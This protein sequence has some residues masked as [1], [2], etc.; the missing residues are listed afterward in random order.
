[1][2]ILINL[3]SRSRD[4]CDQFTPLDH[5]HRVTKFISSRNCQFIWFD[6]L[7][8][9]K[10][11]GPFIYS[12]TT[13][14]IKWN[15]RQLS[16]SSPSLSP[17]H[18]STWYSDINDYMI[19]G[20]ALHVNW[21]LM[22]YLQQPHPWPSQV[23]S[24][25]LETV[26]SCLQW[27]I[28]AKLRRLQY[29]EYLVVLRMIRSHHLMTNF[30]TPRRDRRLG[31]CCCWPIVAIYRSIDLLRWVWRCMSCRVAARFSI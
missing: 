5:H 1:M 9:F 19:P 17:S 26:K 20:P 2:H 3:T 27:P 22:E 28:D 10:G 13:T 25:D 12:S 18:A 7:Y 23:G 6:K 15:D 30:A 24:C 4:N 8:H 14:Q 16:R 21:W 29:F 31:C 11:G